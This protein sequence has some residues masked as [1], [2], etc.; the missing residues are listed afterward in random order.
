MKNIKN[1]IVH[2]IQLLS[3]TEHKVDWMIK[4]KTDILQSSKQYLQG[5]FLVFTQ[6]TTF[7]NEECNSL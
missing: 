4:K 5:I 1:V 2:Y 6:C 3:S 7:E